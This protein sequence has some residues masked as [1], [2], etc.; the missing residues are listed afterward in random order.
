MSAASRS[1]GDVRAVSHTTSVSRLSRIRHGL[2]RLGAALLVVSLLCLVPVLLFGT[3]V[4]RIPSSDE[5]RQMLSTRRVDEEVVLATGAAV[6]LGLWLWFTVSAVGECWTVLRWR[7][8]A[9]T[10]ALPAVAPG[11][12]GWLR[13]LVRLAV[14]AGA[15]LG[16]ASGDVDWPTTYGAVPNAA[17]E[18]HHTTPTHGSATTTFSTSSHSRIRSLL[19]QQSLGTA[20]RDHDH[21]GRIERPL[22]EPVVGP[23]SSMGY[24]TGRE[25]VSAVMFAAGALA[26]L[27]SARRRRLRSAPLGSRPGLPSLAQVRTELTLRTLAADE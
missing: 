5:W 3:S 24:P 8:N 14:L 17:V 6:F 1:G 21:D 7:R 19:L 2:L 9:G 22:T 18:T 25:L 16:A 20:L 13:S 12:T 11:P 23:A 15:M 10:T 4:V 26:L 27:D